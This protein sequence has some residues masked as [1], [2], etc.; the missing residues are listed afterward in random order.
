[1]KKPTIHSFAKLFFAILFFWLYI[2]HL[3]IFILTGGGKEKVDNQRFKTIA[4]ANW[5]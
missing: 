2:P 4:I 3:M 1:M 5:T